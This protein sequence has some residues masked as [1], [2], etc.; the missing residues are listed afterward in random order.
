M[1]ASSSPF[2]FTYVLLYINWSW[3]VCALGGFL[4]LYLIFCLL[5]NKFVALF[6]PS[7]CIPCMFIATFIAFGFQGPHPK[8]SIL[9][10]KLKRSN[11]RA[12]KFSPFYF[13]KHA[14]H[15]IYLETTFAPWKVNKHILCS[16]ICYTDST[17]FCQD[18]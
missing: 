15:Q 12:M 10:W 4:V 1:G 7:I 6:L 16:W 14:V 2:S 17:L 5:V 13:V 9:S 8:R 3:L 11:S 18:A